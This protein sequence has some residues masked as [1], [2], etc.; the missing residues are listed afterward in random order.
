ML[1]FSANLS[2]LFLDRPFLE[3][4][5]AAAASGFKGVEFHFPY[6]FPLDEVADA[7]RRAA[8]EVVLF[9]FPG[10]DWAAGERGIACLPERV[11]EFRDGVAEAARYARG[12]EL[13]AGELPCRPAAPGR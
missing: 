10:G 6:A 5:A 2:F 3:R 8:V 12:A 4:F 9:N 7:I 11:T 13:P 1:R